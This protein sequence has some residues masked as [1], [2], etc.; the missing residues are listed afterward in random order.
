MLREASQFGCLELVPGEARLRGITVSNGE[1][2]ENYAI[3]LE[4]PV[5]RHR[6]HS[7]GVQWISGVE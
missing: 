5:D 4:R 3:F 2:H 1:A 6:R 7:A